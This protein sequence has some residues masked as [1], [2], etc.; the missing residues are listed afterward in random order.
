[1]CLLR[2]ATVVG[3]STYTANYRDS[4]AQEAGKAVVTDEES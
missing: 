1:M 3:G 4:P 2:P